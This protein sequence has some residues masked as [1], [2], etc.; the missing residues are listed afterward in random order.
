M[1]RVLIDIAAAQ[2]DGWKVVINSAMLDTP[3]VRMISRLDGPCGG[4]PV[5]RSDELPAGLSQ[6][7]RD[8]AIGREPAGIDDIR[9]NLATGQPRETDIATFGAYLHA[10]LFGGWWPAIATA[11][12]GQA[13]ELA[14]RLPVTEWELAR[15]PWEIM[16]GPDP[17]TGAWGPIAWNAVITRLV[18]RSQEDDENG[19]LRIQISPR[20]LFVVGTDLGDMSIR[21]GAEFF[22]VWERLQREGILFDFR[23]LQRASS[24]QIE[25]EIAS[26]RPSIVHFICH[27]DGAD[28]GGHID[29]VSLDQTGRP[30]TDRR[31]AG[32]LLDLLRGQHNGYPPI[33]VLSACYS[34]SQANPVSAR[35]N[36]SL[37]AALVENGVPIVVGMGGQVSDLACRL[38]ARRFYEALLKS[39]SITDA[40]AEG[41]RA[42]MKHGADPGRTVDWALPVL[43]I[44][45]SLDPKIQVNADELR[46]VHRRAI[47]ASELRNHPNPLA[48]CDR[49]DVMQAQRA[50]VDPRTRMRVLVLDESDFERDPTVP[51]RLGKFGKTRVLREIA[52]RALLDG[53]LPCLLTFGP[54]DAAPKSAAELLLWLTKA[55]KDAAKLTGSTARFDTELGRL[56][57]VVQGRAGACATDL[58]EAVRDEY[59]LCA[60]QGA[61]SPSGRVIAEALHVDLRALAALGRSEL[62]SSDLRVIVLIDD[63][64]LF[65]AAAR[66][67]LQ[68]IGI[69]G[70]GDADEPAPVVFTYSSQP[71]QPGVQSS[72]S[73]IKK[74][75]EDNSQ[76]SYLS[77]VQL[78]RFKS[79][80]LV[81]FSTLDSLRRDPLA[82]VYHHYLLNLT[83]GIVLASQV[84]AEAATWFFDEAHRIVLGVPSRLEVTPGQQIQTFISSTIRLQKR[85]G[86][87]KIL[88]EIDDERALAEFRGLTR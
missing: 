20:V 76:D 82:L 5:M 78:E 2:P 66:T 27:G 80:E 35:V 4:F 22:T 61:D 9:I 43:F 44:A 41:R 14:L 56:Y 36:A 12:A 42:G 16:Q 62:K 50:L 64:H 52:A 79:S 46:Q 53:H 71:G 59:E 21:P 63:V 28:D 54:G 48:F 17:H 33:V 68:L 24:Q 58:H 88:D 7:A 39:Q 60:D 51:N 6:A 26:F 10:A 15:L 87:P 38:F 85:P 70:L 77:Y 31:D 84:D 13:I 37:A 25:D 19:G 69:G 83:P 8:L 75:V 57:A 30:V 32:R 18:P 55:V 3:I 65:D 47:L 45:D 86:M 72:I 73:L 23:V 49:I 34:A 67:F 29:L 40:T 1:I 81:P 74:F 11:A